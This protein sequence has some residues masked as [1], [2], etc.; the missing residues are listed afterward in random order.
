MPFD[1]TT[2]HQL[3]DRIRVV[4]PQ[5]PEGGGG[6]RRIHVHFEIMGQSPPGFHSHSPISLARCWNCNAT[7]PAFNW[8]PIIPIPAA[9]FQPAQ[10]PHR[11]APGHRRPAISRRPSAR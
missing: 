9:S 8:P 6:L 11:Q 7:S 1:P 3:G 5:P 10:L 2:L 4:P